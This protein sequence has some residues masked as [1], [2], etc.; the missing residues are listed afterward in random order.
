MNLSLARVAEFIS[1]TGSYLADGIVAGYSIDSRTITTGELFF[2]VKGEILDGHDY[3]RSAFEKGAIAA[4]VSKARLASFPNQDNLLIVDDTLVALQTISAAVRR[5]WGK[6]L[7]AITGS[8]GKT[9]TKDAIAHLLSRRHHVLK[10][11]GNLNNHFGLPLQLLKLKREHELAVMEVG[12]NHAGE[13]AALAKI[14]KPDAGVITCVAPVHLEFFGSIAAIARAKF[15]LIES[16]SA[17]GIAILNADDEF[18]SQFGRDFHGRVV[19]FGMQHPADVRAEDVRLLGEAGSSFT[20]IVDGVRESCSLPL[21]GRHNVMNALAAVATALQFGIAPSEAAA[22]LAGLVPSDKRGETLHLAGATIINDCYNSNP[23]A[24]KSMVDALQS[25]PAKR[26]IV[27]VGEM[28]ELGT[29]GPQLHAECGAYMKG[30]ADLVI[31][32]RG[33]A[34]ELVA[35]AAKAGVRSSYVETPEEAGALLANELTENDAV[36]LKAS[37]GVRLERAL[38]NLQGKSARS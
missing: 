12:M 16:L 2:A 18:V 19:T 8:A 13:I 3:V 30:K 22:A 33:L 31:G 27:I 26:H 10:S 37:R 25:L 29:A 4:V 23:S 34:Q 32:V 11:H 35:A 5:L 36:L 28:L 6:P 38:D 24:L 17:G 20:L 14:S 7:I 15:E 21:L 1:A 9:S